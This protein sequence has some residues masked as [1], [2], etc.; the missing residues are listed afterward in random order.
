MAQHNIRR[1]VSLYSYQ[2]EVFLGQ[3]D[4]EKA[5]AASAEFGANGIEIIPEQ[6]YL[7]FPDLSDEQI[8]DWYALHARYGTTPTAYDMFI[9]TVVRK[10]RVMTVEEGLAS[11]VRDIKLAKKLGCSVIRVIINT[12]HEVFEKA[13]PYAEEYGIKLAVEVHSPMTYDHPWV[14]RYIDIIHK[15]DN[16]YLGLLPDMGTFVKRFPRVVSER[17]LRNGAT[18]KLVEEIVKIYEDHNTNHLIS[19]PMTIG[20]A[21]GNQV[22]MALA[23]QAGM[24]NYIDP[25]SLIPHMPYLFHIQ[26]KFYEMLEDNTEYS[27]PYE[28]IVPVLIEHGYNGYLSS[29][30][31]GN[32]HIQ[33]VHVVN[34]VEQVRRQHEMFKTLLGEH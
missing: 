6:S 31:E 25:K 8:S 16:G 20:W 13:A 30:Y 2:E 19:L 22:D 9:D 7:N 32:R 17:A 27:I 5:I 18:P 24:Y 14:Q 4:L 23:A 12:P 21:G 11:L 10:D 34:S 29:E 33:D 26:A 1:G 3:L 28:E 15:V